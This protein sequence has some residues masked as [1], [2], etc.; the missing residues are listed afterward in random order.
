MK[1]MQLNQAHSQ[2]VNTL[3]SEIQN[4]KNQIT[5]MHQTKQDQIYDVQNDNQYS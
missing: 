2:Q 3:Q 4:L 1:Q 5:M